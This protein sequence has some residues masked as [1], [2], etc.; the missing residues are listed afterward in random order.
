MGNIAGVLFDKDGTLF[1]FNATWGAWASSFLSEI[2]RGDPV[3]LAELGA[4]IG[5][6]PGRRIFDRSSPV[7]AGTPGEMAEC[8]L[9]F[10]P[11]ATPSSL[12]NQMNVSAAEAPQAEAAPLKPLLGRLRARHLKLG[13]ATNDAELPA[14]AHLRTA[15]VG[16][17]FDFVAGFDSGYGSKP[18]PG[19]A[20]AFADQ[21]QLDPRDVVFV[22][23]SR[24]D[25][26][27]GQA[28]G[29]ITVAVLTGLADEDDLAPLARV[30]LPDVGALP[31]WL[32]TAAALE[33]VH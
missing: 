8:L 2:A 9:P 25:L 28:A 33:D 29:M 6:D 17:L 4:A 19:M 12:I 14:R 1:D 18:S 11:G 7:I 15:G 22:G 3:L 21:M 5:F 32:E 26:L 23:D 30:V 10:L 24:H 16:D 31:D 20:L 27:T 13:V